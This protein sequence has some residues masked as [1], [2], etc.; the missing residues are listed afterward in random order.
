M[1]HCRLTKLYIGWS[2]K[3]CGFFHQ[4]FCFMPF[5]YFFFRFNTLLPGFLS[6]NY[7]IE[8]ICFYLPAMSTCIWLFANMWYLQSVGFFKVEIVG[9]IC[10]D[11][12]CVTDTLYLCMAFIFYKLRTILHFSESNIWDWILKSVL[13]PWSI[14]S[15]NV[16]WREGF[17]FF[18]LGV[19]LSY[20]KSIQI[21]LCSGLRDLFMLPATAWA[22]FCKSDP[23]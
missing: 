19:I 2:S 15:E 9:C 22:V 18:H 21:E 11:V 8:V 17:L 23:K 10:F 14:N 1:K 6:L 12:V 13:H 5:E 16:R 3:S 20:K 7:H 4:N